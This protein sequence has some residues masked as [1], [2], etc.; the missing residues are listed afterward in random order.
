MKTSLFL[1]FVLLFF[2]SFLPAATIED[3]LSSPF[4]STLVTASGKERVA[5]IF[6]DQGRRNIWIADAPD[7]K[8]KKITNY[9]NDDGQELSALSL[10]TDGQSLVYVHGG[11]PNGKQENPNPSSN[12]E[13]AKQ[14]V[15]LIRTEGGDPVKIGEGTSPALSP[16]STMLVFVKSGQIYFTDPKDPK[17]AK[18]L[19]VARGDNGIPTFSPDGKLLA[20]VSFR[21]DHNFIGVYD[22]TAK[23]L[24]WMSPDVDLDGHPVW[25]PDGKRLA[26]FRFPTRNAEPSG[27]WEPSSSF[28]IMVGNPITGDAKKVW[29]ST[30]KNGGFA[31]F[32]MDSTLMWGANDRLVFYSEGDGWIRI[33]SVPAAGGKE[34]ALT[35]QNCEAEYATLSRD[36]TQLIFNSN[37]E[38]IEH[39][40]LWSV[41]VGGGA[42]KKITQGKGV[43]WNPVAASDQQIVFISS[44]AKQPAA[45]AV[46]SINGGSM[47]LLS[48]EL[49]QRVPMNQL[50][51][52][53]VVIFKSMD[54]LEIHGQLFLPQAQGKHPALLFMHGGPIRQMLPAWHYMDYYHN[55]YGMNQFL[56]MNG[57]VVLSV[58]YRCGIGYG[59]GFRHA[60]NQGPYGASEYQDIVAAARFLEKRADVDPTRIGLWGGSYGG[61]LTAM[62]LARDSQLFSAGV[63]FHGVHDWSLRAR[64]RGAEDWG[65]RGDDM[66]RKAFTSSPVADVASWTSPVLFIMGDDDRNVDFIETTDLVE[67]LREQGKTHIETL[68]FP[69]EVHDILLHQN[70]I[71]AYN[72]T[73]D[74]FKRNL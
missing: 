59:R 40:H 42:A 6:N 47:R 74:F 54:G 27:S 10:S 17:E 55:A 31:Q 3:I 71:R 65:I 38:D 8:P 7:Y 57:Y 18:Q 22:L 9:K 43:E 52:P 25:S 36:R 15:W 39:R 32:Y 51:E 12:P 72:A 64:I 61:Y 53:Q 41:P 48:P 20:F 2:G 29:T 23:T 30:D 67:R 33:Y 24:R 68:I 21:G 37:C 19:F 56:A 13:G 34:V 50:V 69:D 1:L 26:F 16:D 44:T 11:D 66:M 14:E 35:P 5:W 62:G 4:P 58:N 28:S 73:L 60:E 49:L 63:D 45:P 70:W 46:I